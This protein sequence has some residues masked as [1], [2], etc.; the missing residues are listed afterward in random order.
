MDNDQHKELISLACSFNDDFENFLASH[1]SRILPKLKTGI[2]Q[3]PIDNIYWL[4]ECG[5]FSDYDG[6]LRSNDKAD[7]VSNSPDWMEWSAHDDAGKH[8]YGISYAEEIE[9][10]GE[11]VR[12]G[13]YI[14]VK[15]RPEYLMYVGEWS[16][17][18]RHYDVKQGEQWYWSIIK[19]LTD[20]PFESALCNHPAYKI[21]A[22]NVDRVNLHD[23]F[24]GSHD[25][26]W[27]LK[28]FLLRVISGALEMHDNPLREE[29]WLQKKQQALDANL[30]TLLVPDEATAKVARRLVDK[31]EGSG[32]EIDWMAK[33]KDVADRKPYPTI[34]KTSPLKALVR[35]ISLLSKILLNT[36]NAHTGRFPISAVQNILELVDEEKTDEA[37]RQCQERY[38]DSDEKYLSSGRLND[39]PF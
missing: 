33:L 31:I 8:R 27:L 16:Y 12:T 26:D 2:V 29:H 5:C 9:E 17:L 10:E 3:Q 23:S 30:G 39:L 13:R 24:K 38:D 19:R 25:D 20:H 18:E 6:D 4:K 14:P 36:S 11:L 15:P 22:H 28:I 32:A 37:I 1:D 7:Y 34:N 21:F 35:E